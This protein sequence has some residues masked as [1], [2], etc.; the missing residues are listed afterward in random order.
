MSRDKS[1]PI[2]IDNAYMKQ[3]PPGQHVGAVYL[4]IINNSKEDLILNYVHSPVAAE[5]EVH[6]NFYEEGMM[7]MR[8]V[9]HV[10]VPAGDS[11]RFEPGGYHLMF[12]GVESQFEVEDSFDLVLEFEGGK[13]V[14]TRVTVKPAG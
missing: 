14:P 10:R 5:V 2:V 6:R 13:A 4:R 7:Q 1:A 3:M 9:K 8:P 11:L 12:M